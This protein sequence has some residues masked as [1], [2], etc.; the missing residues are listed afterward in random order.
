MLVHATTRM[1]LENILSERRQTQKVIYCTTESFEKARR[2]KCIQKE[3]R[4]VTPRG[5]GEG[6]M[7][8][9]CLM[10]TRFPVG[11]MGMSG[12]L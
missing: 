2:G 8:D 11:E 1:N 6:G 12:T 4:L 10:D 9:V 5:C 7:E 3:S